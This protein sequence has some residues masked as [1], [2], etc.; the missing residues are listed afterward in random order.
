MKIKVIKFDNYTDLI[1]DMGMVVKILSHVCR[2]FVAPLSH[3]CR[4]FVAP[5]SH[6]CRTFVA[7]LSH[8]CRTFVACLSHF[9]RKKCQ[10]I[11]SIRSLFNKRL[12]KM[13]NM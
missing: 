9:C 4:T 1:C 5:L 8:F 3:V 12:H 13:E 2:M 10:Y 6:V 11:K 7:C